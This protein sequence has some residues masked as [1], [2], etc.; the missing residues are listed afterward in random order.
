MALLSKE[1]GILL[2]HTNVKQMYGLTGK[3]EFTCLIHAR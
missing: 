1:I 2:I 3:V